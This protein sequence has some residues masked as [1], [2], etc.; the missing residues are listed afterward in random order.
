MLSA[1]NILRRFEL[2][3]GGALLVGAIWLFSDLQ[4]RTD[5]DHHGYLKLGALAGCA[6]AAAFLVGGATLRPQ[7][8]WSWLGQLPLL[9]LIASAVFLT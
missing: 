7:A 4:G 6:I 8:R 2:L 5:I 3:F 1:T 9:V